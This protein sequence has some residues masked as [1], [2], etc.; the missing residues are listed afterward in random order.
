MIPILNRAGAQQG[1]RNFTVRLNNAV[2]VI[3]GTPGTNTVT[4]LGCGH[5]A[6]QR[7]RHQRD[8]RL[9]AGITM[10]VTRAGGLSGR[11]RREL[12][13]SQRHGHCRHGLHRGQRDPDWTDGDT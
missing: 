12:R 2:T 6:I 8:R 5:N 1:N 10:T 13:D 9:C 11:S 4:I 7:G 3:M